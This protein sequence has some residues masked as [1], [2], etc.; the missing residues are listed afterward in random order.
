[1]ESK[2]IHLAMLILKSASKSR[3]SGEWSAND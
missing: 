2:T 3:P 1:M